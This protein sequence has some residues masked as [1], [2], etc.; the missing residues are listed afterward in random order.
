MRN[1]AIVV[2]VAV[3]IVRMGMILRRVILLRKISNVLIRQ[4][5]NVPMPVQTLRDAIVLIICI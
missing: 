3:N 5:A 1:G 2:K 4:C